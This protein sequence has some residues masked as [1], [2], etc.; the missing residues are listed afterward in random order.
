VGL[1]CICAFFSVSCA[2]TGSQHLFGQEPKN[3]P[4][5]TNSE[6]ETWVRDLGDEDYFKRQLAAI[7]LQSRAAEAIP[8]VSRQ[9]ELAS[10]EQADRLLQFLSEIASNPYDAQGRLAFDSLTKIAK[11]RTT[12]KASRAQKILQVI[13]LAQKDESIARLESLGLIIRARDFQ[14]ITTKTHIENAFVVDHRFQGTAADLECLKWLTQVEFARLEGESITREVLQAILLLPNLKKLQIV[15]ANLKGDDLSSLK[16]A[17]DL[18]LL[19]LIYVPIGDETI[20]LLT[21]LPVWGD[22]HLFGT[23]MSLEGKNSLISKID[24]AEVF[25]SRGG[26]LGVQCPPTSVVIDSVVRGGA[27]DNARLIQGDKLTSING[28][29]IFVFEDLRRELANFAADEEV[30]VEFERP[31]PRF[32]YGDQPLPRAEKRIQTVQVKL[33]RRVDIP[34]GR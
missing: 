1:I 5:A 20:E 6:L 8:F 22:L 21:E 28:R 12:S 4:N 18:D 19:E 9:I 11:Q 26:F 16:N 32:S 7:Q 30:T 3:P 10:G 14:V 34:L 2:P 31:M 13:G 23:K 17:P 25:V 29:P 27:A 33:G 15:D 24:T